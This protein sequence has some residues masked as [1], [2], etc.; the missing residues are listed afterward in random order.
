MVGL[1]FLKA[2]DGELIGL[3]LADLPDPK[4]VAIC[5]LELTPYS[6]I[7]YVGNY[8]LSSRGRLYG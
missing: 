5:T 1:F 4:D 2:E 8:P 6:P 7:F 3:V